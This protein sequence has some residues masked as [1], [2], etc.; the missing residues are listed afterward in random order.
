MK[1]MKSDQEKITP[2]SEQADPHA[3]TKEISRAMEMMRR[4]KTHRTAATDVLPE[5]QRLP[6]YFI[7]ESSFFCPLT[8]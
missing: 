2:E 1:N 6:S 5:D 8:G 7:P 4:V 3:L